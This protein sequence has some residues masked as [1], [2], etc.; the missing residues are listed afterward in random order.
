MF[1]QMFLFI[2]V[3]SATK[4]NTV[5]HIW[6][7]ASSFYCLLLACVEQSLRQNLSDKTRNY[8]LS[9]NVLNMLQII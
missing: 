9:L 4:E 5:K 3:I 6:V 7:P 1:S 2:G 8:T